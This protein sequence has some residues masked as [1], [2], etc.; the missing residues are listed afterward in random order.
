MAGKAQKEI[1]FLKEEESLSWSQL[2]KAK[3][4]RKKSLIIVLVWVLLFAGVEGELIFLN[5]KFKKLRKEKTYL[6]G[7]LTRL[8][9]KVGKILLLKERLGKV[10]EVISSRSNYYPPLNEFFSSVPQG[11]QIEEVK[12]NG[13]TIAVSGEGDILSLAQLIETYTDTKKKSWF[14]RA[15]LNSLTKQEKGLNFDFSLTINF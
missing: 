7:Q 15:T 6:E 10:D 14:K 9:K 12:V 2:E 3:S 8:N 13:G 5:Q 1:N 11:V 4:I